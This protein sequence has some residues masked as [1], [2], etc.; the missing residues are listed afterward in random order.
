MKDIGT[1][2]PVIVIGK[3]GRPSLPPT[4]LPRKAV[5]QARDRLISVSATC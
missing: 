2:I 3:V 1:I 5:T 4:R